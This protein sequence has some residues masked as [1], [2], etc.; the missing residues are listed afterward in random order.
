[1]QGPPSAHCVVCL[2]VGGVRLVVRGLTQR[3]CSQ[4]DPVNPKTDAEKAQYSCSCMKN[5]NCNK[6]DK[7]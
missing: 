7:C 5:C 3:G 2:D 6:G 4:V 1:V